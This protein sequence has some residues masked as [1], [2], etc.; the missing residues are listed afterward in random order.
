[1]VAFGDV[2]LQEA[3][4]GGPYQ[5]GAGGWPTVRYFNT[6]TGIGGAPYVKKTAKAMC[7]ELGD[8]KYMR[9]YVEEMGSTSGCILVNAVNGDPEGCSE[10]ELEFYAKW[11]QKPAADVGGQLTRLKA[12]SSSSMKPELRVWLGQRLNV[13]VQISAQLAALAVKDE[14]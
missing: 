11:R 6:A 3:P 1:M 8:D 7:E 14:V 10:K 4:V 12:M 13:L 5:A 9:E 2:N